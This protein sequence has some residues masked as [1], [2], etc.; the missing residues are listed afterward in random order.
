MWVFCRIILENYILEIPF[1]VNNST[2]IWLSITIHKPWFFNID[3][4]CRLLPWVPPLGNSMVMDL[5]GSQCIG[6]HITQSGWTKRMWSAPYH[7]VSASCCWPRKCLIIKNKNLPQN[8][9]YGL[10]NSLT[11]KLMRRKSIGW[12]TL[13][14]RIVK[15]KSPFT[16][17]EPDF[18]PKKLYIDLTKPYS[19]SCAAALQILI[20]D[21]H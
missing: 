9:V 17:R 3:S 4:F 14:L 10:D 12:L 19:V 18:T 2:N 20:Y 1:S 15:S 7:F 6:K 16:Y 5:Y 8:L 13:K 11:L 21:G